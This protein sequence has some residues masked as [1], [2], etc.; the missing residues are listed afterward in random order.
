MKKIKKFLSLI[1]AVLMM[2]SMSMTAFAADTGSI[3]INDTTPEKTYELYKIF[4]LT[5]SGENVAYTINEDW[6]AF[7]ADGGEG[8]AY[9]VG[10]NLEDGSLNPIAV[11]GVTKYI[12]ITDENVAEFSKAAQEYAS[13]ADPDWSEEATGETLTAAG[14][15]LGYYLVYPK[16]AADILEGNACICSLTST[17]PNGSVTIKAEYPTIEKTDD[18]ESA[19]VGEIVTYTITGKIPDTTGYNTYTYQISDTMSDG[20][21]FSGPVSV[22]FGTETITLSDDNYV[23]EDNGFVLTFE[24]TEYQDQIGETITVTYEA[25]VNENAVA[26]VEKNKAVLTYSNDP[27]DETSTTSTPPDEELV[28][29]AEIVIDK[30]DGKTDAKLANAEFILKNGNDASAKYYKYTAATETE[31]A[32]VEWVDSQDEAT[33]AVTDE[34][35]SA[36]F[37]GLKDGTYYLVEIKAPDGY[38]QLT[39]AV[40][41]VVDGSSATEENLTVLTAAQV[42][43]NKSGT[44]LPSTGGTGTTIFYVVGSILV[45]SAAVLLITRKRMGAEEE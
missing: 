14:L 40:E 45:L 28:Y 5:Q 3:T 11:D 18:K 27:K 36:V 25:V 1:L 38:N 37:E 19:D 26:Q 9:L 33:V 21:T 32:K 29:T 7:F 30:V 24:M 8:A 42:V 10:Q 34:N 35:G 2:I 12:Y 41:I 22:M 16:G 31:S 4:D 43:E 20:L 44:V 6:T 13:G 15:S 39:E 23:K 17:T